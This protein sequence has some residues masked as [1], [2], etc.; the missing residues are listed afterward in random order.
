MNERMKRKKEKQIKV[1][2]NKINEKKE[3]KQRVMNE[4]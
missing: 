3:G 1:N 4:W 2:K